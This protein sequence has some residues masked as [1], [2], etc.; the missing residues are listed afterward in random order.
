[1]EVC[2]AYDGIGRVIMEMTASD[3]AA[4]VGAIGTVAAA[5]LALSVYSKARR[6][7]KADERARRRVLLAVLREY[8][9]ST[10][11][12]VQINIAWLRD[13]N[14]PLDEDNMAEVLPLLA[15]SDTDR[16][17]EMQ[18]RLL[19]FGEAGDA[20]LAAFIE[21]CRRYQAKYLRWQRVVG[22]QSFW[23]T[24]EGREPLLI[25]MIREELDAVERRAGPAL[26][27]IEEFDR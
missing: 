21:A 4:W 2:Y 8:V 1:M 17:V 18:N 9:T 15:I 13:P 27:A 20:A 6:D 5:W 25:H 23:E 12:S 22:A 14:V 26:R 10:A 3:W 16:L 19:D 11:Q 7:A 24:S